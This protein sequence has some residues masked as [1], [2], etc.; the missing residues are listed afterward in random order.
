MCSDFPSF[1]F[2]LASSCSPNSHFCIDIAEPLEISVPS[3]LS[4]WLH[5]PLVTHGA[6]PRFV[7]SLAPSSPVF[8][9][10]SASIGFLHG[11]QL[12]AK[13]GRS[14]LLRNG[15][16]LQPT[17]PSLS[18]PSPAPSTIHIITDLINASPSNGSRHRKYH[19]KSL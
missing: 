16:A 13:D 1:L 19:F 9:N 10:I 18:Y 7:A 15:A 4:I 6:Y 11:Y 3:H 17:I 12:S 2:V 14:V 5:L 8:R